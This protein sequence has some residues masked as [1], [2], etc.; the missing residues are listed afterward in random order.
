MDTKKY[1]VKPGEKLDLL[2]IPTVPSKDV[3]KSIVKDKLLPENMIKMKELQEK[4]Y[5]ENKRGLVIVIQ[6]MDAAG[7]DSM[8][9]HALTSLNPQGT[10]VTSFKT[11]SEEEMDRDYLWRISK[12]L[13]RRGDIAIFNRSHYE[14]VLVTRVHDLIDASQLPDELK[15]D[16]IWAVRYEQINNFEKYLYENGFYFLKFF[17]H[18]SKEEQRERLLDRVN[19]PDKHWKFSYSDVEERKYFDKYMKVYGDVLKNTSKD[20]SP[21]YIVPSDKKWYSR[22]LVSQ[23]IVEKLQS[24]DPKYPKI[25]EEQLKY[26]EEG[27]RLLQNEEK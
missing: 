5:A 13:P 20:E 26:I 27:R 3:D 8:I 2:D 15:N 9:K 1:F 11:P 6:A 18:I 19:K 24:L 23:I 16:E 12:A 14:D 25:S 10:H 21:W 7:K 17:L 22:Y 4:L